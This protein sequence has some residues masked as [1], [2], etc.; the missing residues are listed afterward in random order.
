M[1][2]IIIAD[3]DPAMRDIFEIIF[4]RNGYK[5]TIYSNGEALMKNGFELPN[6]FILDKQLSGVNGFDVCRYLKSQ[7]LTKN[8]PVLITSASPYIA[9]AA[10]EAGANA[11]IE[12]PFKIKEL[13]NT[14]E[15]ILNESYSAAVA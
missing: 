9:D 10:T 8:I 14:V 1:K 15:R 3:D 13:I 6:L 2:H 11:F 5:I 7:E 12:K 4:Q